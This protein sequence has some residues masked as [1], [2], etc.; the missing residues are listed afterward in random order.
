MLGCSY[1]QEV[2]GDAVP[3]AVG[4]YCPYQICVTMGLVGPLCVTSLSTA[5]LD[6]LEGLPLPI[7]QPCFPLGVSSPSDVGDLFQ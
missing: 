6:N 7:T 2:D 4:D 1:I 5:S 3:L